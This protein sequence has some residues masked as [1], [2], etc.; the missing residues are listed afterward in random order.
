M[1]D[2]QLICRRPKYKPQLLPQRMTIIYFLLQLDNELKSLG[3]TGHNNGFGPH[4]KFRSMYSVNLTQFSII[5]AVT[6]LYHAYQ[7][8][9]N[10]LNNILLELHSSNTH[11]DLHSFLGAR[12]GFSCQWEH[13]PYTARQRL[14]SLPTSTLPLFYYQKEKKTPK[15]SV[16][17]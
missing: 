17:P 5:T 8:S 7:S 13:G 14:F 16:C 10:S 15:I 4:R 11:I 3:S 1:L 9:L 2:L 12:A 6:S